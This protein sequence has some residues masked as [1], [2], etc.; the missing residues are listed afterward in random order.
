M[1]SPYRD[2]LE[3]L[4]QRI[5]A[6][7]T[8][9]GVLERSYSDAFWERLAPELPL[10]PPEIRWEPD[11]DAT[12]E[13][14][15]GATNAREARLAALHEVERNFGQLEERWGR[16]SLEPPPLEL[17]VA[18]WT[19]RVDQA[20]KIKGKVYDDYERV[21]AQYAPDVEIHEVEPDGLGCHI[22]SAGVPFAI[23]VQGWSDSSSAEQEPLNKVSVCVPPGAGDVR[24]LPQ[25]FADEVLALLRLKQDIQLGLPDFDGF[26]LIQGDEDTARAVLRS[27]V[28][29]NLLGLARDDIPHFE[30]A[31]GVASLY[32]FWKLKR[33]SLELAMEALRIIHEVPPT[34]GLRHRET[35]S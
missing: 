18:N 35:S 32:W 7:E 12:L 9:I 34:R 20:L 6:L 16:P 4:R 27:E 13:Q 26:F 31:N 3:A 5:R 14:L 33:S 8:E 15:M 23:T 22:Q 24:L 19:T 1:S 21:M 30:M 11:E 2:S 17:I 10:D 25:N 28:R 29:Q